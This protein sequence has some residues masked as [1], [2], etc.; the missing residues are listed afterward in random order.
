MKKTLILLAV[1]VACGAYAQNKETIVQDSAFT[2]GKTAARISDAAASDKSAG[3]MLS[4][5][6]WTVL[7]YVPKTLAGE[8]EIIVSLRSDIKDTK[9]FCTVGFYDKKVKKIVFGKRVK[10]SEYAGTTYKNLNLGKH[11]I[12]ENYY[13]FISGV[14]PK[15]SQPGNVFVDKITF[16]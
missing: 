14:H 4:N 5:K 12:A 2:L 6:G 15:P 9:G 10:I 8:K 7:Y 3:K 16:K 11:K 1:A 13:F